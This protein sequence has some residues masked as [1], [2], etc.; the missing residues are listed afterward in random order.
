MTV[1]YLSL[2]YTRFEFG[3]RLSLFYGQAAVGGALGGI[4]SYVVFS[5]FRNDPSAEQSAWRAWQVLFLLEGSLTMVVAIV[6][7]FWLPHSVETAWFLSPSERS[8]ASSRIIRDR[9]VQSTSFRTKHHENDEDML[10]HDEESRGLLGSSNAATS[11]S[12]QLVDDR[13][14]T[15]RD[16]LSSVF[17]PT[18]WHLLA[19]NILSSLPV[20]AFSV[21]LPLVLAPLL[22]SSGENDNAALINLMT[23]PPHFCGVLTLFLFATY[24]DKH[25]IRL[26]PILCGLLIVIVGLV[27]VVVLPVSWPIA[28]YISLNILLSGTYVASPLTVAWISGNAPMPGKRAVMLGINGWGNMAGIL[29]ALLFRPEYAANGYVVPFWWTL[30]AVVLAAAGYWFFLQR[31]Q[32]TNLERKGI[33]SG[34]SEEDVKRENEIGCGPVRQD[35]ERMKGMA[36]WCKGHKWGMG[37]A[38]WI[39][40]AVEAGR[41]GD[42][43]V[44][45]VYGL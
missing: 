11:S 8:Y 6:G 12:K 3:R 14:L 5:R 10:D 15:P 13:G 44:T 21:F 22:S 38:K 32:R 18:I 24:S 16:I 1:T 43:R 42:E 20:Y 40:E 7:Y 23:A 19:C 9:A 4:I 33:M 36:R 35:S 30:M 37:I 41:Q 17:S 2:F 29:A 45:F 39:E 25:A 28:R 26:K 31:L 27:L 34:W